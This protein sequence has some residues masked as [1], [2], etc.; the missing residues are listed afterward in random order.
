MQAENLDTGLIDY[1]G[2][3]ERQNITKKK[4]VD[5]ELLWVPESPGNYVLKLYA[6]DGGNM[7]A[8]FKNPIINHIHVEPVNSNLASG[9]DT[10]KN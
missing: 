7:G 10:S 2:L 1:V 6:L 3:T 5:V 9:P 8:V 4:S